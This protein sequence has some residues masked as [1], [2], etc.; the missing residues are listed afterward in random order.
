M[1]NVSTKTTKWIAL[2][3][4]FVLFNYFFLS[5]PSVG[6]LETGPGIM[7]YAFEPGSILILGT[8][9]IGL[10]TWGRKRFAK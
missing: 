8:V 2:F 4:F 6:S 10:A 5:S 9:L 3:S 1:K 7:A